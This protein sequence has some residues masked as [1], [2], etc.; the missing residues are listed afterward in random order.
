MKNDGT[1][2][3]L[4]AQFQINIIVQPFE[5]DIFSNHTISIVAIGY[6]RREIPIL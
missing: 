3:Y 1:S 6:E 5:I 2:Y 4:H